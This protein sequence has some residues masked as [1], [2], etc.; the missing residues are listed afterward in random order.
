MATQPSTS[1]LPMPLQGFA[2]LPMQQKLAAIVGAAIVIALIAA[3]WNWSRQPDYAVLFSNLSD[4]DGGAIVTALQQQNVQYKFSEGG[5]AILV[6]GN[7]V[8]DVRLRLAS[9][10][11]PRGGHVG[12]ELMETQKVGQSQFNEQVTYQRALEGELARSIQSLAAVQGARVH[13]AIPKQTGFL[14]EDHKPTASVLLNV[15]PGRTLDPSQVAG[16]VHLVAS[17]V[18][19]MIPSN[20]SVVDQSGKLLS[21]QPDLARS[22]GLDPTQLKY[23]HELEQSYIERIESILVPITGLGNAEAQVTA[24]IDF[25][26]IEQTAETFK[27]N[28]A[29]DQTAIRSQQTSESATREA[30]AAGV[31]GALTNQPPAPATAP[32]TAPPAPGTPAAANAPL[33]LN[34]RKDATINY[35]VDKTIRHVKQPVGAIKR[36]SVA[37]VVNFKKETAKDGKVTNK[38]LSE[39]EMK[40]I[41]DLVREAMGFSKERGD[42]LNVVNSAFAAPNKEVIPDTPLW[43]NPELIHGLKDAGKLLLFAGLAAYLFFGFVRPY[44]RRLSENARLAAQ[45]QAEFAEQAAV[46]HGPGSQA[47]I[48]YDHKL[49]N[50]RELAKQDPKMVANVIKDW[51]GSNP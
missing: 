43:K 15:F 26:Q 13:L 9:Q 49:T 6:P 22:Q 41:N 19:Q 44:L 32:I 3:T 23:V 37:V 10:G 33:P 27:P 50:A 35:E 17:S 34:S 38:A 24:D 40:Q 48:G 2:Q 28:Q 30:G 31:P 51:V 46:Y 14:R 7:M 21:S 29:P 16:I 20:V 5:G 39:A 1:V 18:P 8:H 11:L 42:T 36:L 4:K 12:F 45:R 25:S 47:A